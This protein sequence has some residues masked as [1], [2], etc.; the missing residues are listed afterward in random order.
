MEANRENI[1]GGD[2]RRYIWVDNRV[3]IAEDTQTDH[4]LLAREAGVKEFDPDTKK[5]LVD[6]GGWL[7]RDLATGKIIATGST[8]SCVV[9]GDE[10]VAQAEVNEYL[11]RLQA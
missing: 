11:A 8:T 4:R 3:F 5:P 9:K 7:E 6:S 1:S 2:Q 10:E